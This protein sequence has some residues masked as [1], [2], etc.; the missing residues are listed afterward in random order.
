MGHGRNGMPGGVFAAWGAVFV[1]VVALQSM[2]HLALAL[3]AHRIGSM[4]DLDRSNGLPDLASTAALAGATVGAV[5]LAHCPSSR[6]ATAWA[7]AAILGVLTFADLAHDG[8][9]L[10]S[11]LGRLIFGVSIAGVGLLA[12]VT[13]RGTRARLTVVVAGCLLAASF[14]VGGLDRIDQWFERRRGDPIAEYQIVAKEGLELLGWSL[15]ALALWGH[16]LR[17]TATVDAQASANTVAPVAD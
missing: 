13:A 9:H 12:V 14:V 15:V 8:P 7:L 16:A 11:D 2:A 5:R 6:K 3:H 4:L 1:V 10:S 17:P